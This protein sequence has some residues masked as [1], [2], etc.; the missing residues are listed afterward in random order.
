MDVRSLRYALTLAEELHFGRAARAHFIAAQAFGRRIQELERELGTRLFDR[1][2]RR[3]SLTE[4]GERFLPRARRVLAQLDALMEAA[5]G[6]PAEPVLRIGVLGYGLADRWPVARSVLARCRPDLDLTYVELDW[7][8][9]YDAVR[10]GE[11]DVAIVHDVGGHDDLFVETV[12]DTGRYAVVPADSD[13]ADADR[14]TGTDAWE[15]P[16]VAPVGQPGLADWTGGRTARN[17]VEVRSPTHIPIAVATTGCL[18][19][20]GEPAARFFPHPGVRYL[21]LEDGPR[22]TV[23]IACRKRD[24]RGTVA[25]F[26]NAVHASTAVD[27]LARDGAVRR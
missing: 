16:W 10:S 23:A 4:A 6:D 2:S 11:V 26:R 12:M 3:V 19:L 24:R 22:A 14:L 7:A 20:H 5:E 8:N 17:R 21:P 25:A 1:T 18:G 27:R 9:Q 13:L 15:R